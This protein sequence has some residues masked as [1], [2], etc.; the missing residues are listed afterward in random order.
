MANYDLDFQYFID[1][2][3]IEVVEEQDIKLIN[4]NDLIRTNTLPY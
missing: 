1:T 3:R 2:N 4:I